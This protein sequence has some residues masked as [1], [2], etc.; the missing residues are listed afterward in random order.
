MKA[1]KLEVLVIDMDDIG[2]EAI[3]SEIEDTKYSNYCIAPKVRTIRA[4]DIGEWS[5]DHPL[6]K[7][8][9]SDT[10]YRRLFP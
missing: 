9:T 10:E 2:E 5:D 3:R 6:N 1:F 8:A 7:H 4:Q